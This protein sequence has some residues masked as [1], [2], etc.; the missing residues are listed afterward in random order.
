MSSNEIKQLVAKL[1]YKAGEKRWGDKYNIVLGGG[2]ISVR[3][4]H[5]LEAGEVNYSTLQTLL[6]FDNKIVLCTIKGNDLLSRFFNSNNSDYFIHYESYGSSVKNNIKPNE[7]YYIVTDTY[8]SQ[9]A[10]N[11]LTV[12]EY[13]DD[14]TFA[15]DLVADYFSQLN[16]E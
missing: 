3:S 15:R 5:K 10:P 14:T 8:C 12:V 11:R 1:Y 2:Y 7:T 4:P 13:Y 9:Y 16:K 6:P